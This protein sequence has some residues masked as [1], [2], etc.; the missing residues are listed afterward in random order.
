MDGPAIGS[1]SR[2]E[3]VP[4]VADFVGDKTGLLRSTTVGSRGIDM[5]RGDL[6]GAAEPCRTAADVERVM[7]WEVGS[8]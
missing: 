7:W 1:A 3:D 8:V 5:G 6:D 4:T 2:P